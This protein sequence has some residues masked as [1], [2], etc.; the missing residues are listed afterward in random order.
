MQLVSL[1]ACRRFLIPTS[2]P[3]SDVLRDPKLLTLKVAQVSSL[4]RKT[5]RE[6][7]SKMAQPDPQLQHQQMQRA[8]EA[9]APADDQAGS[10]ACTDGASLSPGADAPAAAAAAVVES[11]NAVRDEGAIAS[12]DRPIKESRGAGG[13]SLQASEDNPLDAFLPVPTS[14]PWAACGEQH[15]KNALSTFLLRVQPLARSMGSFRLLLNCS[16]DVC[17]LGRVRRRESFELV[18]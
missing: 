13:Q 14:G 1:A 10:A 18:F 3:Y 6:Q 5:V 9:A 8:A 7:L 17:A 12:M 15:M 2:Y 16:C 11:D 4:Q